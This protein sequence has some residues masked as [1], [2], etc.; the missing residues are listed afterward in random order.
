MGFYA[1]VHYG[2]VEKVIEAEASFFE[3]FVDNSPGEWIETFLDGSQR[4]NYAG[5]GYSYS[6]SLNG[7][8]PPKVFNSW[9]LDEETCRWVAPTPMP[10]E[11]SWKWDE[12]TLSWIEK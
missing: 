11:G 4:K 10:E 2:I 12:E 1:K 7:F 5:I 9:T 8:I 3:T 6:Q